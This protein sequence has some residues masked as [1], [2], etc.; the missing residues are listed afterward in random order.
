MILSPHKSYRETARAP[1]KGVSVATVA[2]RHLQGQAREM[3]KISECVLC[4]A[5]ESKK[6]YEYKV[7]SIWSAKV[8]KIEQ[9]IL[10]RWNDFDIERLIILC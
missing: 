7:T 9:K 10:N 6:R 2:I 8:D 5:G 1:Q 4:L 3:E